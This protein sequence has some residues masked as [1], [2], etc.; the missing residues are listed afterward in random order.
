MRIDGS[1]FKIIEGASDDADFR[2]EGDYNKTI[3]VAATVYGRSTDIRDRCMR[4]HA[5]RYGADAFKIKGRPP[6]HPR[7]H[8]I[9]SDAHDHMAR[10]TIVNPD[11]DHRIAHLGLG[12]NRDELDTQGYTIIKRAISERFADEIRAEVAK[13]IDEVSGKG[14]SAVNYAT[15]RKGI[16]GRLLE[17]GRVFE[18]AAL[19]PFA[20]ALA[21]HM[22]GRG[23]LQYT[24]L[25]LRKGPGDD[26]HTIHSDYTL[27]QEPYPPYTLLCGSIWALEEFNEEAGPTLVV[28]GSFK[29]NRSPAAGEGNNELVPILM[30]KGSIAL[31]RGNT[32]HSSRI[33]TA[34]G[35]RVS[36]HMPY[37]RIFL[38]P[39]DSYL[40]IDRAILERN[41]PGLTTLCGLD[42]SFEKSDF[43]GPYMEGAMYAQRYLRPRLAAPLPVIVAPT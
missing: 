38:R 35:E 3:E 23:C 4:E 20:S 11:L 1:T 17:R 37:S 39:T 12:A 41:P 27:V 36:L 24:A 8:E 32:W 31:W 43:A 14:S 6:S 16:A 26:T 34:P 13:A 9:L 29:Y 5:H 2:A 42:D 33:R 19:H 25:G 30:P 18:E 21:E 22:C 15:A 10:R 7:L 40:D 28:P